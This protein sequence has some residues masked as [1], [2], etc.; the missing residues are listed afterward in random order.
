M[1]TKA[2]AKIGEEIAALAA[3]VRELK[4][5][6][7]IGMPEVETMVEFMVVAFPRERAYEVAEAFDAKGV[8]AL[9]EAVGELKIAPAAEPLRAGVIA[10]FQTMARDDYSAYQSESQMLRDALL[11]LLEARTGK[12]RYLPAAR[13]FYPPSWQSAL[14][15]IAHVCAA[16]PRLTRW[17][18]LVWAGRALECAVED[19][20]RWWLW[21]MGWREYR[22]DA[23]HGD[24]TS[25]EAWQGEVAQHTLPEAEAQI[26]DGWPVPADADWPQGDKQI[27]LARLRRWQERQKRLDADH[28]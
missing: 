20:W 25:E 14:D 10:V 11:S 22:E 4:R 16:V 28:K 23:R 21:Q 18:V 15:P 3:E 26:V 27:C 24:S 12:W 1:R 5:R 7:G 6:R 17:Q 9:A 19:V 2:T 8:E 13:E